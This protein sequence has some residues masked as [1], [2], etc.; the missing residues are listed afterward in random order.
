MWLVEKLV[1]KSITGE[2]A[3]VHKTLMKIGTKKAKKVLLEFK[4][5]IKDI[6]P[7]FGV[8]CACINWDEDSRGQKSKF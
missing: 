8:S 4:T 6:L 2:Y 1:T 5:S 7:S 3:K